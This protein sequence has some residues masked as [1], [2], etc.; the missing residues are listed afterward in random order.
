MFGV[1]C[2]FGLGENQKDEMLGNKVRCPRNKKSRL[3]IEVPNATLTF[4]S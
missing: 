3:L 1:G 4:N 2:E